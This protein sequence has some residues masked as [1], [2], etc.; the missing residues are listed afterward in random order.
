LLLSRN[1]TP[2]SSS[3]SSSSSSS[4]VVLSKEN[5]HANW[6][7]TLHCT[8]DHTDHGHSTPSFTPGVRVKL[9]FS[10]SVAPENQEYVGSIA[11][12]VGCT[13]KGWYDV[14]LEG[15]AM[16]FK[17]RGKCKMDKQ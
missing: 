16:Q 17:W 6:C 11:V 10:A 13:G 5:K 14:K 3:S 8:S 12:I 2:P 15:T 1:S 9:R 7:D 4:N